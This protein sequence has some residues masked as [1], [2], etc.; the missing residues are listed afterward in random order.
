VATT[1]NAV[2]GLNGHEVITDLL[3]QVE[4]QLQRDCNLTTMCCYE[5]GYEAEVQVKLKLHGIDIEKVDTTVSVGV[6]DQRPGTTVEES[7]KVDRSEQLDQVRKRSEQPI[8][9]MSKE[10]D[11][12]PVVK[13]RRYQQAVPHAVQPE[14]GE[15]SATGDQLEQD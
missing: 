8:P 2:Q 9:T 10:P 12:K 13:Q 14:R 4:K 15:G 11:G 7:V 6:P 3:Y 1:D 5:G